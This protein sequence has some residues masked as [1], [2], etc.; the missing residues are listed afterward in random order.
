MTEADI[1]AAAV[2]AV[3]K[4][5]KGAKITANPLSELQLHYQ[6]DRARNAAIMKAKAMGWEKNHP[7]LLIFIPQNSTNLAI[8]LK[9][10]KAN[11]F[12]KIR[13]GGMW[14]RD[15]QS[16]EAVRVREQML[17]L[18]ELDQ[19]FGLISILCSVDQVL[20]ACEAAINNYHQPYKP[21]FE[22]ITYTDA[23]KR[24]FTVWTHAENVLV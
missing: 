6:N 9:T 1:Q 15:S 18:F 21:T 3:K 8:E 13:G 22:P 5:Y 2:K 12:R 24:S 14:I 17:Y 23:Y 20:A 10:P 19:N 7:D 16:Q 4:I 11:P